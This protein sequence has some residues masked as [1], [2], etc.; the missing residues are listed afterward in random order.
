MGRRRWAR[1]ASMRSFGKSLAVFA[2]CLAAAA[3]P[4]AAV[5]AAPVAA[6]PAWVPT[7]AAHGGPSLEQNPVRHEIVSL[8]PEAE[9]LIVGFRITSENAR[10]TRIHRAAGP[11]TLVQ[12]GTAA[13]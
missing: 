11:R 1:G 2:G 8:G 6:D 9:R 12:A 13:G 3:V 10:T 7:V 5:V 4:Q